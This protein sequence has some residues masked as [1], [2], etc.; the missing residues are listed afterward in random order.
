MQMKIKELHLTDFK[1]VRNRIIKFN[2][3]LTQI[4]GNNGVGKTTIADAFYWLLKDC[5]YALSSNPN[6]IPIGVSECE[7]TVMAV[8]D[9]D[10]KPITLT[11]IQKITKKEG[12]DGKTRVSIS[13]KY[14]VNSSPKPL[15]DFVKYLEDLDFSFDKF[16]VCSNP[17]VF[18]GNKT[19]DM[20]VTL[21]EMAS[22]NG[23]DLDIAKANDSTQYLAKYLK[24]YTLE[25]VENMTRSS[26]KKCKENIASIPDKIKGMEQSKVQIDVA[27]LENE[28]SVLLEEKKQINSKLE[29]GEEQSKL[30]K[31]LSSKEME[32]IF[33]KNDIVRIANLGLEEKRRDFRHVLDDLDNKIKNESYLVSTKTQ[34]VKSLKEQV[35]SDEN[36]K[37]EL[38]EQYTKI[39]SEVFDESVWEFDETSKKCSLCGQDLPEE[40]IL[41]L[42]A[43][44]ENRKQD[45]IAKFNA[46]QKNRIDDVVDKGT[47]VRQAI[48]TKQEE[49]DTLESELANSKLDDLKVDLKSSEEKYD[50][51][52]RDADLSQNDDYNAIVGR[53]EKLQSEMESQTTFDSSDLKSRRTEIELEI[54]RINQEIGKSKNNETIDE[55]I[56]ELQ[57]SKDNYEQKLADNERLNGE[58]KELNKIKNDLQVKEIN[59]YFN[60]VSW[61]L[62][63]YQKN[64]EIKDCCVPLVDGYEFKSTTN[65]GR[66]IIAMLDIC[67]GFQEFYKHY[68]P[69]WLD[70][71]SVIDPELLPKLTSQLITLS[72]TDEKKVEVN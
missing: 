29:A 48:K 56:E 58:I 66:D 71:A 4:T 63:D 70:E 54:D 69:V 45:A 65:H 3:D 22:N 40:E 46:D 30:Y 49:I 60:I 26:I 32:L 5:N 17:Y 35:A 43:D 62:Y 72:R 19:K 10:G 15:K 28:K 68:V 57:T 20:R 27:S 67:N 52:P 7:P 1:G 6:I 16:M 64:G 33:E 36:L 42:L 21:F 23:T 61:K 44:F 11:K 31:D 51:L 34:K 25:E 13:N 2:D 24:D 41:K 18:T 14:E 12:T 50:S 47:R 37:T 53:I 38:A 55:N 39:K 8:I 59:S 9:I